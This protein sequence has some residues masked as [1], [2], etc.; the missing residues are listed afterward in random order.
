MNAS[1]ACSTIFTTIY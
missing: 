1:I